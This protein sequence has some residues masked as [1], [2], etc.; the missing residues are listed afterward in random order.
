MKSSTIKIVAF[1]ITMLM[2]L[3]IIQLPVQANTDEENIIL[4]KAEN[5]FIIY[6]KDICNNEFQFAFSKD[7]TI[8]EAN[9]SF[10]NSVKDQLTENALYVAYID[11]TSYNQVVD[12]NVTYIWIKDMNDTTIVS[13]AKLDLG[14]AIDD[15]II[16]VV[17]NT[18]KR[19]SVDTTQTYQTNAIID[20]VDTTVTTGKVVIEEKEGAKYSYQLI[21]LTDNTTDANK[22]FELA[23]KLKEDIS[24]TYTN[25]SLTKQFYDLYMKLMPT[26]WT[27]VDNAE[28]LQPE[29]TVQGDKYILYLKEE[30]SG[31]EATVDSKFL[32]CEYKEDQG[33]DK[34]EETITETV[35]LPVTYDSIALI[36]VFAI[37]ILAIIIVAILKVKSNK[38]EKHS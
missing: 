11:E 27:D 10:T 8:E 12:G 30:I 15:S 37:V 4:K 7:Q 18:T 19:I 29:N 6:Y 16:A 24:D 34:K 22:L 20:G 21:R 32:V 25:L 33:S 14:N 1:F 13:G 38:K 31:A 23:E 36:V 5:E 2:L 35:K 3:S 17:N 28:I 9:L 26:D